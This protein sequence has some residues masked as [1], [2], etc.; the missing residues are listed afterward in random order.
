MKK[1]N[2]LMLGW[3]FPPAVYG[4][5]GVACLGL[6]KA[7]SD[8][9]N[10]SLI[11]PKTDPEF[12]I[13]N[14]ELTGLNNINIR[15]LI[16]SY[17]HTPYETFPH[18]DY[19]ETELLPYEAESYSQKPVLNQN[20]Q[21]KTAHEQ[22]TTIQTN[23][24]TSYSSPKEEP[25]SYPSNSDQRQEATPAYHQH[26]YSTNGQN[27]VSKY[28]ADLNTNSLPSQ[29]HSAA[30]IKEE[31]SLYDSDKKAIP[32][33]ILVDITPEN[34]YQ[35]GEL[36]DASLSKKVTQ[37]VEDAT[38]IASNKEFDVIHAHDWMTFL[39]G[40][41]IKQLSGKPLVLHV[42]SLDY[43]RGGP[44]NKG[45]VYAIE[46]FAM[47]RADSI[48]PVS[49]YTASV[50][51][52]HYGINEKKI[53]S[54]HN[55][56]EKVQAFK[57]EKNFPER[58]VLFLGRVTG[59]KGPGYFLNIASKVLDGYPNARFV[60]AGTGDQLK[61]LIEECAKSGLGNKFHFTG[62]LTKEK[63][64]QLLAMADVYCMPSVSE[65]FGLSALEAAQFGI[66]AVISKQSGAA[67]VLNNA[68]KADY[69]D[70]D[71]MA[72]HIVT[73]LKDEDLRNNIVEK[74]QKDVDKLTWDAS[75]VG[76]MKA[77]RKLL[78]EPKQV[79]LLPINEKEIIAKGYIRRPKKSVI[80]RRPRR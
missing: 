24:Q 48:I 70:I 21:K 75:A 28:D 36:Y 73:L 80:S 10:L 47:E 71:S 54:V 76:I 66:P 4:G 30:Q 23:N 3:E 13:K 52:E 77:Y 57:L 19:I 17:R 16:S 7:L 20:L 61:H 64:N 25:K 78:E 8:K 40:V 6:S 43:D 53:Q 69:W 59:Q 42:H 63:V 51:V 46:K 67:E 2:V 56:V 62:F 72:N 74:S 58:L 27:G 1:I 38:S 79:S 41:Q 35:I 14:V 5:L 34:I 11:L 65:P 12:I 39:A 55:G 22:T 15:E 18:A 45:W 49:N 68:L 37:F 26:T 31:K 9:V 50:I 29:P 60:M 44:E 32:E 33:D